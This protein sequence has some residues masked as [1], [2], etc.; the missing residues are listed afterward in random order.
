VLEQAVDSQAITVSQ[1]GVSV[2]ANGVATA[3]VVGADGKVEARLIKIG[4][5]VG[6]K[7]IVTDGLKAG[8]QVI[9]EGLQKFQPGMP[10]KPVPFNP[11]SASVPP[12]GSQ[13][14]AAPGKA[15]N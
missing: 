14:G 2:G 5:A 4:Q 7:W 9:V 15:G 11:G 10:V 8:D 1:R 3:M 12:A 6:D 13:S